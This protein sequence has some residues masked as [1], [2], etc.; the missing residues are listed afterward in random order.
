MLRENRKYRLIGIFSALASGVL[1]G[2]SPMFVSI[3][4][5]RGVSS[6]T[7]CFLRFLISM[8]LFLACIM[9]RRIDIRLSVRHLSRLFLASLCN[10]LTTIALYSCYRYIGISAGTTIHFS[11]PILVVLFMTLLLKEKPE[12][13]CLSCAITCMIGI[14][15]FFEKRSGSAHIEGI[16]LALS[17]AFLYSFYLIVIERTGISEIDPVIMGFYIAL[18]NTVIIGTYD[19]FIS[20]QISLQMSASSW[21]LCAL[22]SIMTSVFATL[23]L[24]IAIRH[25]SSILF[26]LL[27]LSEPISSVLCGFLILHEPFSIRKAIGCMIIIA[28]LLYLIGSDHQEKKTMEDS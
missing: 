18:F 17:S 4:S 11:Y 7:V 9:I 2:V 6:Y 25:T 14:L 28:S 24:Q 20:H 19:L 27:S 10:S 22:V 1:F 3:V 13:K 26:S 15:F 21:I 12:R 5:Q 23:C 16:V 8:L